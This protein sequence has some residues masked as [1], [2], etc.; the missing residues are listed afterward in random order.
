AGPPK[1]WKEF[2][3]QATAIKA[4]GLTPLSVGPRW[5]QKQLLETVLLGEL[6][7]DAYERL[8]TLPASWARPATHN[9]LD[10]FKQVL[11]MSDIG[12]SAADWQPQLDRITS[13]TAVYAVMGDWAYSYL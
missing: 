1:T 6:G 12:S 8:W 9:A 3:D 7:A 2:L 13:G 11:A 4:K 10:V 5:T